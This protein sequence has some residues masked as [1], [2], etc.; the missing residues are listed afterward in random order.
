MAQISD[1]SVQELLAGR[2]IATLATGNAD[3]SIHMVAVWYYFDGEAIYVATSGR[4][5]K[6]QNLQRSSRTSLMIDCRNPAGQRGITIA[7]DAQLL[8]GPPSSDWNARYTANI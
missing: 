1:A 3:G 2:Y 6:A 7:G 8:S 5:R 4:S